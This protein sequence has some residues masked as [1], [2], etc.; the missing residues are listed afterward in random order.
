MRRGFARA[1]SGL[2]S[3]LRKGWTLGIGGYG[4][5]ALGLASLV[6]APG[7][8]AASPIGPEFQVDTYTTNQQVGA[9]VATDTNGNFVVVWQSYGSPSTDHS[10]T[11]IQAQRYD[12][13]GAPLGAQFQV[14]TYT[15]GNQWFP[16]VASDS[17]GRFVVVW[18]SQGSAGTDTD[19]WSV[20]GQRFAS[21]GAPLGAQFQVNTYTTSTQYDPFVASDATGRFV[22]VWEGD[23]SAGSDTSYSSIHGQ[24][25]D[26]S[27]TPVGSEFQVNT[28]TTSYQRFP[29]VASDPA[30]DFVVVWQSYGSSGDTDDFS[31]QGQ[32]YSSSGGA[33]GGQFQVNGYTTGYQGLP[34]VASDALGNFV[35]VWESFGSAGT[36]TD[37]KSIQG[38]RYAANGAQIGGQFQV[39]SYTTSI[40]AGASVAT[41]AAGD[42]VVVWNSYGSAG[43]DTS[44]YSVQGQIYLG[45][46]APVGGQFQV[47]TYTTSVQGGPYV[48]MK[49]DG[50]SFVAVWSGNGSSGTDTSL[51]SIHGQRYLPEPCSALGIAAVLPSLFALARRRASRRA[52]SP[53]SPDLDTPERG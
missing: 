30:G 39:D 31:V 17:S 45:D 9:R 48:A 11:S 50:R 4:A 32:R 52:G 29:S 36:D 53:A 35:V 40:Q 18:G 46:G 14:N 16:A 6:P 34:S 10:G 19:G 15:T 38:Q 1:C 42:F 44:D 47:N 49:P 22:V 8:L 41:D 27:G 13:T 7:A 21:N 24:R 2:L 51:R 43:S 33:L 20:Q 37:R 5:A 28:Y 12:E 25:Y 26:S 3:P 23:G